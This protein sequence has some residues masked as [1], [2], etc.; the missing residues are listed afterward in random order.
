[1]NSLNIK[2]NSE[3]DEMQLT[4]TITYLQLIHVSEGI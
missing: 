2:P 4:N 1:L 3:C